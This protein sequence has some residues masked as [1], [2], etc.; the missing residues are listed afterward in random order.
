ML[1][2]NLQI[3]QKRRLQDEEIADFRLWK[4]QVEGDI[5]LS[6]IVILPQNH[7]ETSIQMLQKSQ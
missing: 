1:D 2:G 5:Y 3:L 4:A 6:M 7:P